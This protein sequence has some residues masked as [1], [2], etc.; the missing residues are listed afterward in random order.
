MSHKKPRTSPLHSTNPGTSR[1]F[2]KSGNRRLFRPLEKPRIFWVFFGK[3]YEFIDISPWGI[4]IPLEVTTVSALVN[5]QVS[6]HGFPPGTRISTQWQTADH[7]IVFKSDPVPISWPSPYQRIPIPHDQL[8]RFEN[9]TVR[10]S[11]YLHQMDDLPVESEVTTVNVNPMVIG[12][13]P[14]VEGL[15]NAQL[16]VADYPNGIDVTVN[17]IEHIK[18]YGRVNSWWNTY[19]VVENKWILLYIQEQ[20]VRAVPGM[21]YQ[22][23]YSPVAYTGYPDDAWATCGTKVFLTPE[24]QPFPEFGIGGLDFKLI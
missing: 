13:F 23:Q 1:G 3:E 10:V 21:N 2:I 14:I 16:K 17:A 7:G 4:N 22:F 6:I 12:S 8:V 15:I 5:V 9:Q 20:I 11:Y 18:S 24:G 19:R